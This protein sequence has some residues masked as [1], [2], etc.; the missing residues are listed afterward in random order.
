M[1]R[2]DP[3]DKLLLLAIVALAGAA[4]VYGVI[5]EG[6]GFALIVGALLLAAAIGIALTSNGNQPG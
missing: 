6:L 2:I 3:N 5:Y 4:A 1:N